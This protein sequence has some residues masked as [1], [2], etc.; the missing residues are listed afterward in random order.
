MYRDI[1]VGDKV[2]INRYGSTFEG[3]V[4]YVMS[5][6]MTR[7]QVRLEYFPRLMWFSRADVALTK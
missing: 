4:G 1:T 7:V 6:D 2:Q 5:T 3:E